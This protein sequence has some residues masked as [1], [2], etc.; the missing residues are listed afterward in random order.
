M[1]MMKLSGKR[2]AAATGEEV[3]VCQICEGFAG[4]LP[5]KYGPGM[6]VMSSMPLQASTTKR[7]Q[8]LLLLQ[9]Y[10]RPANSSILISLPNTY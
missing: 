6:P 4:E 3:S 7:T 2:E 5:S 1:Y 9:S 10:T 8:E